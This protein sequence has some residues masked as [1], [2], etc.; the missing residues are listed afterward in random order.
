MSINLEIFLSSRFK[1]FLAFDV[2]S[3]KSIID[4]QQVATFVFPH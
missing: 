3:I 4:A 2:N 1:R